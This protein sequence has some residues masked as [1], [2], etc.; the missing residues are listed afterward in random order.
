MTLATGPD[1]H[2]PRTAA[3]VATSCKSFLVVSSFSLSVF[4]RYRVHESGSDSVPPTHGLKA[5]RAHLDICLPRESS[6]NHS[7]TRFGQLA[8]MVL[9]SPGSRT[10]RIYVWKTGMVFTALVKVGEKTGRPL[11]ALWSTVRLCVAIA[12]GAAPTP[13]APTCPSTERTVKTPHLIELA[14][15]LGGWV[16]TPR[17]G[18]INHGLILNRILGP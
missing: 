4:L 8:L 12:A 7:T 2:P 1:T 3:S 15:F 5:T 10:C 13:W 17:L 9:R 14:G 18:G 6:A 11:I 16:M